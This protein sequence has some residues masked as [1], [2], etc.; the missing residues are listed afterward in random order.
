M[1]K[2]T[3]SK[4]TEEAASKH[5][6]RQ[7]VENLSWEEQQVS[8]LQE[9]RKIYAE[10][11]EPL[12][13]EFGYDQFKPSYFGDILTCSTPLILFIGPF[14]AGKTTFINY[15]LGGDYLWTGPEPTTN[16]F[17]V[18]FHG[19]EVNQISGRILVSSASLPFKGLQRFGNEF[20]EG[21]SG[22]QANADILK[23]ITLVDTPGILETSEIHA[24]SYD[25]IEVMK[26]FV[27]HADLIFVMFDP[28]KLDAGKELRSLFKVALKGNESRIRIVL[29]K[30]D[31]VGQHELMKVHGALFWNLSN[32]ISTSEPPRVYVS[33]FWAHP[34]KPNTNHQLFETEKQALMYDM[35]Y[36]VPLESLDR[37]V[38]AMLKRCQDVLIHAAVIGTARM[39]LPKYF[40]KQKEKTKTL[41]NLDQVYAEV[42]VKYRLPAANFPPE[43]AYR[44]FF[45]T[46]DLYDFPKLKSFEEKGGVIEKLQELMQTRIPGLLRSVNQG[47]AMDPRKSKMLST[48]LERQRREAEQNRL[49]PPPPGPFQGPVTQY[50]PQ[51]QTTVGLEVMGQLQQVAR[52]T[53]SPQQAGFG[54]P[55]GGIPVPQAGS[56]GYTPQA[57]ATDEFNPVK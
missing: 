47:G 28:T 36:A 5:L 13:A 12:E 2:K 25:Y 9:L 27:E 8:I 44:Q 48:M 29:N 30:S 57:P 52:G 49:Q 19:D 53:Y 20:L 21:F 33:S 39:K 35:L 16:R 14:S 37:K 38:A 45:T 17:T 18:V 46:H 23:S 32:L 10:A 42:Q 50:G 3:V 4:A 11:V 26:W 31:S 22:F 34:Y 7:D 15:L 51:H 6:T 41:D 54:V 56:F 55:P 1:S 43:D 40:G 24:R